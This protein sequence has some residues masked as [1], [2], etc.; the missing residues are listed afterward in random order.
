MKAITIWQPYA[1]AIAV[2][3][4][5][6]ETRSWPTRHR[7]PLA[8]HAAKKPISEDDYDQLLGHLSRYGRNRMPDYSKLPFG[9]VI[10]TVEL[11]E[12]LKMDSE[13]VD[14]ASGNER[15]LGD[16]RRG[17][18]AW[19]ISNVRSLKRPVSARG[20]QGLWSWRE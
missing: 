16:W 3:L 6:F 2:G 13:L 14:R 17:R 12:C 15:V 20:L 11:R 5:H 1:T 18:Y 10:A 9:S 4:K 8:I 7:G 19:R